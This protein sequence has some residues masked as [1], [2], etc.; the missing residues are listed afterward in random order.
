MTETPAR[1]NTARIAGLAFVIATAALH[2][3]VAW[4]SPIQGDDWEHLIW[5]AAHPNDGSPEYALAFLTRHSTFSDLVGFALARSTLLHAIV[6]PIASLAVVW[7][8]FTLA[9]RR[10]PRLDVWADVFGLVVLSALLWIAMP[11]AGI[12]WFH[13]PHVAMWI[14]GS[15][16]AMWT[17]APFRCGWHLRGAW[18]PV[19]FVAGLCA[20][21]STRQIGT[22]TLIAVLYAIRRSPERA[23]W[24]WSALAG[25]ALGTILIY[26]DFPRP[27]FRGF[28]PSFERS[29]ESL[30]LP[31]GEGGELVSLLLGL[32]MVKLV[33]ARLRPTLAGETAPP[34]TSETL[35]LLGVWFG[36]CVLALF[37]PKSSESMFFPATLVLCIAALPYVAWIATSPVMRPM[38]VALACGILAI[39]WTFSL[40][41]HVEVNAEF[42][43]RL[44]KLEAGGDRLTLP[45]Y[46]RIEPT[47]WTYGEDWSEA[48]TRQLVAIELYGV[49]DI[50]IE[51]GYHRLEPNPQLVLR[52]ETIGVSAGQLLAAGTPRWATTPTAARRQF[53]MFV[54]RL[55]AIAG[56]RVEARLVI[57]HF[58]VPPMRG[59]PLLAASYES[60]VLTSIKTTRKPLD[61]DNRQTITLQPRSFAT[62]YPESYRVS[63]DQA[64]PM[65]YE[66]SGYRVQTMTTDLVAVI[67]CNPKA[68]FLIDA[69]L[70]RL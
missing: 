6:S 17:L 12:A 15:A 3:A 18:V 56:P 53:E 46:S 10:R 31:I 29:L 68:C 59:R 20:G 51:P 32:V 69:F 7:G 49:S 27:D 8:M 34:E 54:K 44:A 16:V 2:G 58:S 42:R 67:G 70:P 13:R 40:A 38:L 36:Y 60:G 11:R 52:L 47:F 28:K 65:H 4:L 26:L 43:E 57:D 39:C 21:S 64:I 45:P 50:V 19:M 25:V 41:T 30:N 24:M 5:A 48:V 14:F 35:P 1:S 33:I 63:G 23:R 55:I 66:R 37:G 62:M 61:D 22:V 9:A